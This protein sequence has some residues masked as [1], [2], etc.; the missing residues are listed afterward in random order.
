MEASL[1]AEITAMSTGASWASP[2]VW[3]QLA[4]PRW[5]EQTGKEPDP[6]RWQQL[7]FQ[8]EGQWASVWPPCRSLSLIFSSLSPFAGK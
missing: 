3:A 1:G 2:G 8:Q 4:Q 6:G 5:A 7:Q